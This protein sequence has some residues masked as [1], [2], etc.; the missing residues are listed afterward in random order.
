MV[1]DSDAND[2]FDADLSK[3]L[4][5]DLGDDWES[6]FQ[7][8]EFMLSPE[9]EPEDFFITDE[10]TDE[11]ID[12]A[13]LL[14]QEETQS[15]EADHTKGST[16][17]ADASDQAPQTTPSRSLA[18]PAIVLAST[19]W[20]K[21]RPRYQKI[22]FPAL[23]LFIVVAI[24][25]VL[26]FRSTSEQLAQEPTTSD[27]AAQKA[28]V[29]DPKEEKVTKLPTEIV[30]LPAPT[31]KQKTATLLPPTKVR[32][33]WALPDFFITVQDEKN[34]QQVVARIDLSLILFLEPSKNIPRNKR[35]FIRN[36]IYQFYNN[37]TPEELRHYSLARGEMVRK[38]ESWLR[39]DWPDNSLTA[40][41][42]NRYEIVK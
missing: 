3:E 11:E 29:Q 16:G 1:A 36:S 9:D 42:F 37:R 18:L 5:D 7:A 14:A 31:E 35:S 8:E 28:A 6:A 24:N 12:L 23:A 30:D 38:L 41:I 39:K 32:K 40:I 4:D 17:S 22:L 19:N 20:F 34:D 27:I 25:A 10:E 26:F 21:S 15:K 33:K 13:S 2:L